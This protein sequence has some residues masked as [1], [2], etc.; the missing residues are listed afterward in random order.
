LDEIR[1]GTPEG[2]RRAQAQRLANLRLSGLCF[3]FFPSF[4]VL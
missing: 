1:G 2:A 4:F 3:L